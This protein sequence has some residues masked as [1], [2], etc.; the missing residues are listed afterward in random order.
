MLCSTN[1]TPLYSSAAASTLNSVFT[2]LLA[3]THY[4]FHITSS[5]VSEIFI[6]ISESVDISKSYT[7]KEIIFTARCTCIS[8]VFAVT[9]LSEYTVILTPREK[10]KS[11]VVLLIAHIETLQLLRALKPVFKYN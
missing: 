2:L 7:R 5:V 11:S 4:S 8:A 1:T 9:R 6:G 10:Q 3:K